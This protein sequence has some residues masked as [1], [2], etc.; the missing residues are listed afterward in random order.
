MCSLELLPVHQIAIYG[1]R[2][3]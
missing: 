3:S 1:S 2:I